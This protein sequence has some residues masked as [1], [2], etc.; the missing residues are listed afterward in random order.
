MRGAL[1]IQRFNYNDGRK[2]TVYIPPKMPKTIVLTGDGQL[3]EQWGECLENAKSGKNVPSTMIVGTHRLDDEMDRLKEYTPIFDE[4]IFRAHE[5]FFIV[6]V[7]GWVKSRFSLDLGRERTAVSGVSAGA[8]L[9]L[10]M[11][12]RHTDLFGT[13][14]CA[15]PG[16]GYKPPQNLPK[17]CPKTY[18]VAGTQ[19]SFFLE[20]ATR[21]YTALKDA[22]IDV[23]MKER[24]GAH[25]GPFWQEEFPL[26]V[27]WAFGKAAS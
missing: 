2:V 14:L 27:E 5:K 20:N 15:S 1:E 25:G 9:A 8:E 3:V 26:M 6:D 16:A 23:V 24:E 13:I 19:E 17:N 21:W 22:S 4:K 12:C 10:S 18:L 11:G 7:M